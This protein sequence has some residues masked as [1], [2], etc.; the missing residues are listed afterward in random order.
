MTST[1]VISARGE[2]RVVSGHPWIYRTDV[3]D[4]HASAGEIVS[5]RNPRGRILGSALFSDRSQIALRML[6][7]GEATADAALIQRRIELANQFRQG[8]GINGTAYRVVHGEADL[9]P[10]LVVDRYGEY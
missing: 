1:V 10:S 5:V 4:V 6:S 9:L 3:G 2:G 7:Y 8:L